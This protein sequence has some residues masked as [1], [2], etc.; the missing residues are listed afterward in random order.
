[1]RVFLLRFARRVPESRIN[2][3]CWLWSTLGKGGG[4]AWSLLMKWT[5]LWFSLVLEALMGLPFRLN[6]TYQPSYLAF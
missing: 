6:A 2:S 1:M 5:S 3:K 4:P